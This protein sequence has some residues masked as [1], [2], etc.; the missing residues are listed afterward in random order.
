LG[1]MEN[2]ILN[3]YADNET[4]EFRSILFNDKFNNVIAIYQAGKIDP[5]GEND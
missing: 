1:G 3:W 2:V 5:M 4:E